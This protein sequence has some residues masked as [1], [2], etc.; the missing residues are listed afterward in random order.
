MKR[1]LAMATPFGTFSYTGLAMGYINATAE[2]QRH[3]NNTLGHSLWVEALVIV[4]D[5]IV[6][7]TLPWT[8]IH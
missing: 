3:T 4:D 6:V 2:F 7:P 5:V 1:F 8:N